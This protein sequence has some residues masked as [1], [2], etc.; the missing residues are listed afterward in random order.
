M[1]ATWFDKAYLDSLWPDCPY[2]RRPGGNA[3]PPTRR[4]VYRGVTYYAH[5]RSEVRAVIKKAL[6]VR[7]LVCGPEARQQIR[8]VE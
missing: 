6:G 7:K 8:E 5:T 3:K 4:W 2:N 1:K